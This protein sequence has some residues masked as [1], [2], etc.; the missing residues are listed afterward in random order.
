MGV[1]HRRCLP[2]VLTERLDRKN[3]YADDRQ[4]T[5]GT[6]CRTDKFC[7]TERSSIS[8]VVPSPD[9]CEA[10]GIVCP[11]LDALCDGRSTNIFT[12][13]GMVVV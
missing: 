5:D 4:K 6:A 3:E 8:S 9:R 7:N 12:N 13:E 11:M 1:V 10:A 2:D